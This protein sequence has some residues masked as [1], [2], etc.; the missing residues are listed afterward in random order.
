M[1]TQDFSFADHA[2]TFDEH[3]N[4]SIPGYDQLVEKC[5]GLSRRFVQNHTSV[6]DLGCTTGKLLERLSNQNHPSR[7]KS[8]Y[9]GIDVE[10]TFRKQWKLRKARN[11]QFVV[12]DI[13]RFPFERVSYACN[14][15]TL[16]FIPVPDK[17]PLLK[18]IHAGLVEGGAM[19]IAEKIYASTG[20]LQDALTF[21][22]YDHKLKSF[23]EC[24]LL[25]KERSLRGQMT[26]LTEAELRE[27]L[28]AAGFREVEAVWGNFPF[29]ALLALK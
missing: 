4:A 23:S 3:I 12:D 17:I 28:R 22:F 26:L 20:R 1:T 7:K 2:S 16:P 14:L 19:L 18:R 25:N 27:G 8:R 6:V 21:Q 5:V 15:F 29:L 9:I 13:C 24:E 10:P 11:T